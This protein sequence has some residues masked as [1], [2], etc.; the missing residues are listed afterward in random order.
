MKE[1]EKPLPTDCCGSGCERCVY[2]IYVEQLKQY[3][4]WQKSQQ[5]IKEEAGASDGIKSEA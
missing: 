4:A 1:P 3:K 2:D 5:Q